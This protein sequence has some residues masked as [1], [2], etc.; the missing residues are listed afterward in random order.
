M[1]SVF[2]WYMECP[3]R[4][5]LTFSPGSSKQNS[6]LMTVRYE[7]LIDDLDLEAS[8]ISSSFLDIRF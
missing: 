6:H 4:G 5:H 8:K 2:R 7:D 3:Q 1:A